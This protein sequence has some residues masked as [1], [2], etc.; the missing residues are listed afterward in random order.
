MKKIA[1]MILAI[2]AANSCMSQ[3]APKR[4]TMLACIGTDIGKGA[5][6]IFHTPEGPGVY[7]EFFRYGSGIGTA[8]SF[9]FGISIPTSS[10]SVTLGA[11]LG[12]AA[13]DIEFI[14]KRYSESSWSCQMEGCHMGSGGYL[15]DNSVAY[16]TEESAIESAICAMAGHDM[17]LRRDMKMKI[18][19]E[20]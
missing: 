6:A 9:G 19:L 8:S 4:F 14:G 16:P 11:G 20:I 17:A 3:E 10:K 15:D 7:A 12:M 1:I 18:M 13:M 5:T 2:V